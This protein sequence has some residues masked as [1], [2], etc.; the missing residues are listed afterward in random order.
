MIEFK[1]N[2]RIWKTDTVDEA[3]ALRRKLEDRDRAMW[4]A[5]E[6]IPTWEEERKQVWSPDSVTELL[7][8][9][10]H[11]QGVF[12]RKLADGNSVASEEMLKVL[13]LKS[14]VSFAGVLSGLSK[15]LKKLAIPVSELYVVRVEWTG[16]TKKRS[17]SLTREFRDAAEELG[18]PD[19]WEQ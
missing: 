16:K 10:G 19:K 11:Q 5:G 9:I 17:F 6:E 8:N 7:K 12:L 3:I 4:E 1:H 14:E 13:G 2:G 18:W 15:Q